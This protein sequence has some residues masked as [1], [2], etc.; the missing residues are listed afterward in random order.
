MYYP[1]RLEIDHLNHNGLDNRR[2]NLRVVTRREN[3]QNLRDSGVSTYPGVSLDKGRLTWRADIRIKKKQ[4]RL[5]SFAS[6]TEAAQSYVEACLSLANN[7]SILIVHPNKTSRYKGVCWHKGPN[8]W[9]A[10]IYRDGKRHHLG[11]YAN[12]QEAANAYQTARLEI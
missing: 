9:I 5:G 8:K 2:D 4:V 11:Y 6:E 3:Q 10:S 7:Q 12:E 1:Q